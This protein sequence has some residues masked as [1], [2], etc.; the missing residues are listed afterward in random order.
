MWWTESSSID[1]A[2]TRIGSCCGWR[3]KIP[4]NGTC[5]GWRVLALTKV[6]PCG[7]VEKQ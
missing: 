7:G 4:T 3:V 5:G 6:G 1:I 2:S